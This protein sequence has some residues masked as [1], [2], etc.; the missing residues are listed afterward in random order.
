MIFIK[1]DESIK[2]RLDLEIKINGTKLF[3]CF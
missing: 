2:I 3:F 1:K